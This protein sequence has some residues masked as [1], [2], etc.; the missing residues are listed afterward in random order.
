M[1]ASP[2]GKLLYQKNVGPRGLFYACPYRIDGKAVSVSFA[3][4]ET[5]PSVLPPDTF[6]LGCT[7]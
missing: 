7:L 3:D 5:V 4:E 1:R 2:A 6:K